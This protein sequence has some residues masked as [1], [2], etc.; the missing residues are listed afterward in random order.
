ISVNKALSLDLLPR[1]V[2]I[3]QCPNSSL[4]SMNSGRSSILIPNTFLCFL[5]F[6]FF[7]E[8][9]HSFS[10]KSKLITFNLPSSIQLY[11]AFVDGTYLNTSFF[12]AYPTTAS[13]D[14]FSSVIFFSANS[15]NSHAS[16]TVEWAPQVKRLS[17]YTRAPASGKY[18]V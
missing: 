4:V 5:A 17:S 11:S 12:F 13:G 2:S 10:G 14:L 18:F 15:I 9:R 1:T 7:F 6:L 8:E 16:I 3:S